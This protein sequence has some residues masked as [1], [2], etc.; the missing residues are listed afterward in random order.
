MEL[1][2]S[3]HLQWRATGD[4][5]LPRLPMMR[6]GT[7]K[8]GRLSW[9]VGAIHRII[10]G[11]F[12]ADGIVLSVLELELEMEVGSWR[13]G[14]LS[15]AITNVEQSVIMKRNCSTRRGCYMWCGWL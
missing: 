14:V 13:T 10:Q 2:S 3:Q 5:V 4:T 7:N 12:G 11:Y 15:T 9:D 8:V 6:G 1:C